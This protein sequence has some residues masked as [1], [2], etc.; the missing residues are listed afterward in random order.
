MPDR[1]V[2]FLRQADIITDEEIV[3]VIRIAVDLG[4]DKIRL[5]GGEPLVRKG[6]INLLAMISGI[7]GIRDL[8]MTTNGVLLGKYARQL[9]STGLK[10]VNISLDALD[11]EKYK[12]ISGRS[13][14]DQVLRGIDAAKA[15]GLYPIKINAVITSSLT[16]RDRENLEEFCRSKD[17]E[18]RFIHQMNLET[19]TFYPVEGGKGGRC[20]SCNR[21]RLT[22]S[23]LIKP[24]LFNGTG[25]NLRE[26]GIKRA[27]K[28]AVDHKPL[29]GT[30]N[31]AN[32]F[33]NIGG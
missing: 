12:Y 23:G 22:A 14:V 2:P 26:L 33:Y 16:P 27:M 20:N 7:A 11:P 5:T 30:V 19:G 18:L 25:Y 31:R 4:I 10:R 24:C 13:S 3:E 17:L 15:A 21:I 1:G 6:I 29:N 9:A 28:L 32:A 8:A